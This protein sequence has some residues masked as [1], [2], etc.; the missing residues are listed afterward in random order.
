MAATTIIREMAAWAAGLRYQDIPER[1]LAKARL[2]T[3]SV[4][5]AVHSAA[6]T[7]PGRVILETA[8]EWAGEGPCSLIPSAGKSSL[9]GAVF[10]AT[11]LSV[12]QDYDD[13]LLFGHTGHSAVLVPLLLGEKLG[14]ALEDV[15][16]AQ[17]IAN[18]LEGRLGAA[19]L[20]GP[21]NGQTWSFIH[22]LGAAA[23]GAKLLKLNAEQTAH[24]LAVSLYQPT[25]VLYPGFMGP[26]SKALTPAS[27]SVIGVQ[28]ALLA[29]KGFTG[30]LDIIE[31]RQGFLR[32]F[33]YYP[34]PFMISGLGRAWTTD[35]LAYKIYPG[36]A[37]IDTTVDA[38]LQIREDY[39]AKTGRDLEPQEVQAVKVEATALTV[40][41]DALSRVGESFDVLNPVSVNF[42]IPGNVAISL[43]KGR[44][45]GEDL[46]REALR[47]D[48]EA[49]R[50]LAA[51]VVLRHD[52]RLTALM[53]G[54]INRALRLDRMRKEISLLG[55]LRARARIQKQYGRRMGL[56]FRELRGLLG[57]AAGQM[58]RKKPKPSASVSPAPR[59]ATKGHYDLG[60]CN[61]EEFRM[62]FAARVTITLNDGT[63]LSRQQDIPRGG[64][65][66]A[67]SETEKLIREKYRREASRLLPGAKVN[68][69]L[70]KAGRWEDLGRAAD[71]LQ[72][73]TLG[74]GLDI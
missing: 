43:L 27:P 61:L 47:R 66:H 25:Y 33:S 7:G 13:Y 69:L 37:Y 51:K 29:A 56:G 67:W 46:E 55:I 12:A 65:G 73:V 1:V 68:A 38:T 62:P 16:T 18:E 54:S 60:D 3:L 26:D 57:A 34:L 19:V 42:S 50:R 14:S 70:D 23:A 35:T 64:P 39:R 58:G 40:E 9:A 52:V 24:A 32:H 49:I 28:A 72:L 20:L 6:A 31:N 71:L 74:S 36:C 63:T 5:A 11:A 22:L 48:G 17:V 4:L 44:L 53:V 59:P 2:Q 45:A 8:R 10:A 41:M 15:L 21:H 30:A